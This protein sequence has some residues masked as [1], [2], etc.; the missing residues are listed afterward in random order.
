MI[1]AISDGSA[2]DVFSEDALVQHIN[3]D[4]GREAQL[5]GF[6]DNRE[7]MLIVKQILLCPVRDEL[8][9]FSLIILDMVE[10]VHPPYGVWEGGF[11][12][13]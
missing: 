5:T 8:D 4:E 7:G 2:V 9:V 6:Q 3:L 13:G 11:K 12:F 10:V 1:E